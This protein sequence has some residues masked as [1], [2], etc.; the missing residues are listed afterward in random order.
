VLHEPSPTGIVIQ[1]SDC[2]VVV[3]T[4]GQ[5]LKIRR[6]RLYEADKVKELAVLKA[7]AMKNFGGA[8]TGIGFWGSP[9]WALGG[10]AVLGII[11]GIVSSVNRKQG[12]EL[13]KQAEAKFREIAEG[14]LYF[15]TTNLKNSHAPYPQAW[16]AIRTAEEYINVS[17]L[18][19]F[20]R[21]T[22]LAHHNKS[23]ADIKKINGKEFLVIKKPNTQYI[24]DGDEFVNIDTT[25][26]VINIRWAQVVAYF[27]PQKLPE[28]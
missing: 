12:L 24:H 2:P 1:E 25:I 23:E 26:G 27:P 16:F 15:D 18:N 3:L 8:S 22:L 5:T 13:L 21:K 20:S 11:E 9:A 6:V 4:S 28:A 14:A 10:A 19:W 7:S 17:E